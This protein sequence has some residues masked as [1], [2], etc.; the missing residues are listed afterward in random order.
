MHLLLACAAWRSNDGHLLSPPAELPHLQSLLARLEPGEWS[1]GEADS[2]TP[3]HERLRAAELGLAAADGCLP[4]A[5]VR[6]ASLGLA[7]DQAWAWVSPVHWEIGAAAVT[8]TA[9]SRLQLRED[10]S[11]ALMAAM[12]PYFAQDGIELIFDAADR[13]LARSALFEGLASASMDRVAGQSL[14]PWMPALPLL[15]RLQSEMQMLL[16]RHPVNDARLAAGELAVNAFWVHGSGRLPGG[17][18]A[19]ADRPWMEP[20]ELSV[21]AQSGDAEAWTQA[22]RTIDGR[23]GRQLLEALQRSADDVRLSLCGPSHAR[24]FGPRRR[25]TWSRWHAALRPRALADWLEAL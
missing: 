25:G 3:P 8:M 23:E 4:W 13:W 21:A 15:R 6:S 12:Q 22:W 18:A 7:A 10:Q 20:A 1:R 16:Y 14:A 17:W 11:R 9:A 19:P 24:S 2:L 5:A